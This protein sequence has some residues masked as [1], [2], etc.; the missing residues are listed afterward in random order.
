MCDGLSSHK[1]FEGLANGMVW[2]W[3]MYGRFF[4]KKRWTLGLGT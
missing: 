2:F 4:F 3:M 1:K